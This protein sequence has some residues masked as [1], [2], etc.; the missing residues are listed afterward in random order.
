MSIFFLL[1]PCKFWPA[2]LFLC[3]SGLVI[4]T[5]LC[6]TGFDCSV[7]GDLEAGRWLSIELCEHGVLSLNSQHP[8]GNVRMAVWGWNTS[9]GVLGFKSLL[10][11]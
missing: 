9:L 8:T 2:F 7:R 3:V 10:A 1:S 6:R 11:R 4:D 5:W